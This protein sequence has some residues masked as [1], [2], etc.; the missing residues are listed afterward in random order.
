MAGADGPKAAARPGLPGRSALGRRVRAELALPGEMLAS[1][2]V[3]AAK[4]PWHTSKLYH[5]TLG[6]NPPDSLRLEPTDPWPGDAERGRRFLTDRIELANSALAAPTPFWAPPEA[7]PVWLREL[8]AFTWVRDLRA[9]GSEQA[10]RRARELLADWLAR[11]PGPGEPATAWHPVPIG[12]RIAIWLGNQPF[13][14]HGAGTAFM[15]AV[16]LSI[17]RQGRHL[18]RVLPGSLR[19]AE[20]I[21]AI[22]GLIL[23]GA[24]FP[25]GWVWLKRGLALLEE[26]LDR[27]LHADGGHIA[28]SPSEH[29][30]VLGDLTDIRAV[31]TSAQT[32]VP[33]SLTTAIESMAPVL[34]MLRH[35]D[36]GLGCFNGGR[37][38]RSA[39]VDVALQRAG[40]RARTQ[41][42]APQSGFQRLNAQRTV[43]IADAGPP[44]PPGYDRHAHAAPL[45]FELSDGADRVIVN[46]GAYP[47]HPAW[48]LPQRATAAHS[49][50]TLA[51]T[52]AAEILAPGGGL[53]RKPE[54]V[55]CRRET[56]EGMAW[57]AMSHDGYRPLF[58][59]VHQRRLFL[60]PLGD[61]LRGEDT[62]TGPA[63]LP[64]TV[65]FHIHP[66]VRVGL[67]KDGETVQLVTSTG[68][69]WN[70][71]ASG[72]ALALADSVYLGGRGVQRTSQ[73]VLS[74]T[75]RKGDTVVKWALKRG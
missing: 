66:A 50:L 27:Q 70:L 68:A 5:A 28:R 6:R 2:A 7:E 57:L 23:A 51:E 65:R 40:V 49:T 73:I 61:D 19:G 11:H 71:R 53:G 12:R 69:N 54:H 8:H 45:A 33:E 36:G 39:V 55:T 46:C 35:G 3:E 17:G 62:L 56:G 41:D 32:G 63:D 44:P 75:T 21:A 67:A 9:F 37:E 43:L 34:K 72:A 26:E 18:Y 59:A 1:R 22:K 20:L 15:A 10:C 38:E 64:F 30:T 14:L 24:C 29:L 47:G 4:R 48:Q 16:L 60:S 74:G 31:L 52:N 13:L 25:D 58:G 42:A